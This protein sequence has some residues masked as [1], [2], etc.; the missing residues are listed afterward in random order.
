VTLVDASEATSREARRLI[1]RSKTD[2][3]KTPGSV[4]AIHLATAMIHGCNSI[5]TY[6]ETASRTA[7]EKLTS[8]RVTEPEPLLPQLDL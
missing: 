4:D 7:W 6:E 2:R 3:V 1:R 5:F 8:I